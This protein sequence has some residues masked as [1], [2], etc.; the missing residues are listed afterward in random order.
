MPGSLTFVHSENYFSTVEAVQFL[1]LPPHS[2]MI[3]EIVY[4]STPV[5]SIGK[6]AWPAKIFIDTK[7][8]LVVIW[9]SRQPSGRLCAGLGR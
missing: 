8:P 6:P 4:P 9:T 3:W 1:S 5:L 7:S 2:F